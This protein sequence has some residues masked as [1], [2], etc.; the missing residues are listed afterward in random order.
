MGLE[1]ASVRS[2]CV[3]VAN[4]GRMESGVSDML[5]PPEAERRASEGKR[6]AA[7][8]AATRWRQGAAQAR[9][10]REGVGEEGGS[11]RCTT[12]TGTVRQISSYRTEQRGAA[13]SDSATLRGLHV[14]VVRWCRWWV[15][16][17]GE[18]VDRSQESEFRCRSRRIVPRQ[19]QGKQVEIGLWRNTKEQAQEHA[20]T[21]TELHT[22]HA[23]QNNTC[24]LKI[25]Q[26]CILI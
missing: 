20:G 23:K 5:N 2:C 11:K 21:N 8:K 22:Q 14:R 7:G 15:R 24:A 13:Q 25:S 10:E 6:D 16:E 26:I 12:G 9:E 19:W 4:D 17:A 1:R 3:R 18:L